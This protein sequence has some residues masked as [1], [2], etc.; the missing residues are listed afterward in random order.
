M[1]KFYIIISISILFVF[2][3]A[4]NEYSSPV[5]NQ[6][7]TINNFSDIAQKIA[8]DKEISAENITYLSNGLKRLS[9]FKDS[10]EGK[11]VKD[12][13]LSEKEYVYQFTINELNKISDISILRLNTSNKFLGVVNAVTP[14][15]KEFNNLYFLLDNK[16]SK[17]IKRIAGELMF[18]YRPNDKNNEQMQLAPINFNYDGIISA[19]SQDTV[20]LNQPFNQ[21]DEVSKL[22]RN[23]TSQISGVMNILEVEFEK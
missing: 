21:N 17:P 10:I 7:F 23:N 2:S 5:F 9:F 3:C 4:K 1:K 20:I 8:Q 11:T 13:I 15:K 6:K 12:I 22:F 19:N 16:Y 14:D 18:F